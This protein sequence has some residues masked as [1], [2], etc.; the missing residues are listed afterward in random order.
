MLVLEGRFWVRLRDK[1]DLRK[2]MEFRSQSV[3]TLADAVDTYMLKKHK[4]VTNSR[5]IIGH[6][7]SDGKASRNTCRPE[8]ARAIEHCLDMPPGYLFVDG[9]SRV[10]RPQRTAA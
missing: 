6:L 9:V 8:L 10:S 1:R 4:R 5:A 3:R 2:A 7:R